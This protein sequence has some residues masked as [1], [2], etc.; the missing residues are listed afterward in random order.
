M[1]SIFLVKKTF[2]INDDKKEAI[3]TIECLRR[4]VICTC[5]K[6]TIGKNNLE[7]NGEEVSVNH[8]IADVLDKT[9]EKMEMKKSKYTRDCLIDF[10]AHI[11]GVAV[12]ILK[13]KKNKHY[14]K[15]SCVKNLERKREDFLARFL[16]T[17]KSSCVEI[18]ASSVVSNFL[19][20]NAVGKIQENLGTTIYSHIKGQNEFRSK[21]QLEKIVLQDLLDQPAEDVIGY[22]TNWK[23]F[24][25]DILLK[26]AKRLCLENNFCQKKIT[27][28]LATEYKEM[29]NEIDYIEKEAKSHTHGGTKWLEL[30]DEKRKIQQVYLSTYMYSLVIQINKIKY[31]RKVCSTSRQSDRYLTEWCNNF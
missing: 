25:E 12:M 11:F 7:L 1:T 16:E 22:S 29:I 27:A 18:E 20:K 9:S 3:E 21:L 4:E 23:K 31:T 6:V 14:K 5:E 8:V 28:I 15:F 10:Y 17:H 24:V 30:F 13:K 19:V 2:G 26:K